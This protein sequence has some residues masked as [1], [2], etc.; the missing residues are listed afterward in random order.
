MFIKHAVQITNIPFKY[1]FWPILATLL[2]SSSRYTGM[3]EDYLM[4]GI[5]MLV[6]MAMKYLKFSRISFIIGF[7]LSERIERSYVQFTG[8]YEWVDLFEPLPIAFLVATGV[9]IVW[10]IFYNKAK[11]D[12]V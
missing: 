9:A 12:F 8:L 5:C 3:I 7:I 11:I 6:G 10:G 2:W 4:L 1:Y